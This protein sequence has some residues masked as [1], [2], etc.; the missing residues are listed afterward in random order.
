MDSV[1][2]ETTKQAR[3]HIRAALA[4]LNQLKGLDNAK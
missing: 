3:A 2:T 1:H 4:K